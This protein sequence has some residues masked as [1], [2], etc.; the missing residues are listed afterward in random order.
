MNAVVKRERIDFPPGSDGYIFSWLH[1]VWND[2]HEDFYRLDMGATPAGARRS[3]IPP[4][5]W[6]LWSDKAKDVF[7][8]SEYGDGGLATS[9]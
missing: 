7:E 6:A 8:M 4:E 3:P 1:K 5:K 9:D 2:G